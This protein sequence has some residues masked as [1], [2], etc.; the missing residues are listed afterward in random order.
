MSLRVYSS[1]TIANRALVVHN[2][3]VANLALL[4]S[5][6]SVQGTWKMLKSSSGQ[7]KYDRQRLT[8]IAEGR[9]AVRLSTGAQRAHLIERFHA[10]NVDT[11]LRQELYR[12]SVAKRGVSMSISMDSESEQGHNNSFNLRSST[13]GTVHAIT[14]EPETTTPESLEHSPSEFTL[15]DTPK[16]IDAEDDTSVFVREMELA[17]K[18]SLAENERNHQQRASSRNHAHG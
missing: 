5:P 14:E 6:M 1:S 16:G 17:I 8:R 12:N 4:T 2:K 13:L 11:L 15:V 3:K 7:L 10:E 18:K 9:T